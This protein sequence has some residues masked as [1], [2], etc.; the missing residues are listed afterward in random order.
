MLVLIN[1]KRSKIRQK[2]VPVKHSEPGALIKED[3]ALFDTGSSN[4]L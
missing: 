3:D 4:R 2:L 1:D